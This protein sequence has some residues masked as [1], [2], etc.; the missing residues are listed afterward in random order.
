MNALANRFDLNAAH[1]KHFHIAA[2]YTFGDPGSLHY[3]NKDEVPIVKHEE[4]EK[5]SI[6][7]NSK[8][9]VRLF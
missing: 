4:K 3:F 9:K 8:I 1:H 5:F 6:D 2:E 7:F